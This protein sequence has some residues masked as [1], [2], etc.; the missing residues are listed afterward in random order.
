MVCGHTALPSRARRICV[1]HGLF[2]AN[3]GRGQRAGALIVEKIVGETVIVVIKDIGVG[4]WL[5]AIIVLGGL[6]LWNREGNGYAV[7]LRLR[8]GL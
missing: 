7:I 3:S 6:W 8:L 5:V 4:G 2:G 1:C